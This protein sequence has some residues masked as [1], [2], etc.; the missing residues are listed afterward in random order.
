MAE[1]KQVFNRFEAVRL[2]PDEV[3]SA[4]YDVCQSR[5]FDAVEGMLKAE[6]Q[7]MDLEN[8]LPAN[9]IAEVAED[10]ERNAQDLIDNHF[11]YY[12]GIY[13]GKSSFRELGVWELLLICQGSNDLSSAV[14]ATGGDLEDIAREVIVQEVQMRVSNEAIVGEILLDIGIDVAYDDEDEQE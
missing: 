4:A 10:L 14:A 6:L 13:A 1:T 11:K 3:L 12:L 5:L 7:T 9:R 8:P 2:A